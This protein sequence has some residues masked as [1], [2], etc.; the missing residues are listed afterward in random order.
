MTTNK[1]IVYK[2]LSVHILLIKHG[3]K[4]VLWTHLWI[5]PISLFGQY[6]DWGRGPNFSWIKFHLS[7]FVFCPIRFMY[8]LVH[9]LTNIPISKKISRPRLWCLLAMYKRCFHVSYQKILNIQE[10]IWC[11]NAT[12][13]WE[14]IINLETTHVRHHVSWLGEIFIMS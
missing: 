11:T 9:K 7:I 3:L 5:Q 4:H 13:Y 6:I 2:V 14:Q 8:F 12:H 10:P 1:D